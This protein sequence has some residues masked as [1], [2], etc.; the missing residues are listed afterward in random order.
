MHALHFFTF[1]SIA[2][3]IFADLEG[4]ILLKLKLALLGNSE[5]RYDGL[6][7]VLKLHKAEALLYYIALNGTATRD[8]LK[9]VFWYDKNENQ[10][11]ANLR[12]ALYLLNNVIPNV[13]TITK[14]S[15]SLDSYESDIES[16][17][18]IVNIKTK[19]PSALFDPPLKSFNSSNSPIFNEWL[20]AE[21]LKIK[22]KLTAIIRKRT[23]TAYEAQNHEAVRESLEAELA[24]DPFD[25]DVLL[26][27]MESYS[28]VGQ[29]MQAIKI[30][31]DFATRI[32][33]SLAIAPSDRAKNFCLKII[34]RH[35]SGNMTQK[36]W[37]REKETA[38][39]LDKLNS[40]QHSV[41]FIHG[42]AGIG[43]TALISEVL[44]LMHNENMITLNAKSTPF[45]GNY[46]YSAWNNIIL[47]LGVSLKIE[48]VTLNKDAASILTALA[49]SFLKERV[50]S[51]NSDISSVTKINPITISSI[52][53][54]IINNLSI[55]KNIIM[56]FEDIH[57]FDTQSIELLNAFVSCNPKANIIVTGRPETS[58][59]TMAMLKQA[60][61]S[62]PIIEIKL[63]PFKDSEISY[64]AQILLPSRTLK[65]R[66]IAYF[67]R[68]SEGLPLIL[69]EIIR[70]LKEN[71]DSDCTNGLGGLIIER[72]GEL[73]ETDRGVLNAA[74]VS[75]GVSAEIISEVSSYTLE[76][77]VTSLEQLSLKWL[78]RKR[79]L[80]G[81]SVFEFTHLKLQE[82]VYN[83]I[84]TA[85][86]KE[87]HRRTA[88]ALNKRYL[89]QNWDPALSATISTHYKK[90][91]EKVLE[92]KQYLRELIFDIAL[93]NDLFP[94]LSD[95]LFESCSMHY[96]SREETDKKLEHALSILGELRGAPSI[97]KREYSQLEATYF[98]LA[99]GYRV[100]I[101]EYSEAKIYTQEAIRISRLNH[102]TETNIHCLK[103]YAYMYLQM[104]EADNLIRVSREMLLL[105]REAR[106]MHYLATS[107]RFIG[108]GYMIN[109]NYDLAEKIFKHSIVLFE[110]L[111]LTG[112]R[113]TLEILVSKCYLG[114][115]YE[116]R[117]MQTEAYAL[118]RECTETCEKMNLFWGRSYFHTYAANIALTSGN[119][120]LFFAHIDH[121]AS[122]FESCR[123]GRCGAILY[124]TKAIADAERGSFE[125]ACTA[126]KNSELLLQTIAKQDWIASNYLA[127]AWIAYKKGGNYS[128][129]TAKAIQIYNE[130]GF[131]PRAA[132][133][134]SKF[135]L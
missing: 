43:K 133:V 22:Q 10:A 58:M 39:L 28:N 102:F 122:I 57:W 97:S 82:C 114:G 78:L 52:F 54:H 31:Q 27:L 30:Y 12:N 123:G 56:L 29:N 84:P 127:K 32:K 15:V 21:K 24:L 33:S 96:N 81:D 129:D 20:S 48:G 64:I 17:S 44:S 116:R 77:T 120:A 91:G 72:I 59:M 71:P 121:A 109:Q 13:L 18:S 119:M 83:S 80:L 63:K 37:C 106:S 36:F 86:R 53:M 134:K 6:C 101:G 46:P 5:I 118:L 2:V 99:G 67:V 8:E 69:F 105:C 60:K 65:E 50:I 132:W 113:Y 111:M 14:R 79:D 61:S 45:G 35:S 7:V 11:S 90:A 130:I 41:T 4:V 75:T 16:L 66:G 125:S 49:P 108:M 93:N 74:A 104:E 42:E 38:L 98:E 47:D 95:R 126:L 131:A 88:A 73:S 112:R 55:N 70:A 135:G 124:S 34:G 76:E 68:E 40:S 26:E 9:A 92:L 128:K 1:P 110:R 107:V 117:D 103:H 94:T 89:P 51:F 100:S 85:K 87:L 23:E 19:I 25:E 62:L 115:I 3:I